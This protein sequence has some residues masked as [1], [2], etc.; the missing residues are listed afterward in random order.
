M[1]KQI[2][3]RWCPVQVAW[4]AILSRPF[5][6]GGFTWTGWDYRGEPTPYRWPDVNSHF[7][8]LDVAGFWKHRAHWYSACWTKPRQSYVLH[9]LPHWNWEADIG[10]VDVWAYSNLEE[11]ELIHP[12]GTSLGR[13]KA[14]QCAH[15]EWQVPY[16]PGNLSVLG[17]MGGQ[18]V[19]KTVVSTTGS[20]SALRIGI[21]DGVG[22]E[23]IVANGQDVGLVFVEVVDDKGA[24]VPSA[25]NMI[26][27]SATSGTLR[28]SEVY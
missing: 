8:I 6:A 12:N 1:W 26:E 5:V 25:S 22:A 28:V 20:P 16:M 9:L 7:G 18:V 15:A 23:G 3:K 4:Q 10:S 13:R 17:Y 2:S 27:V 21:M 11:L 19:K 14:P 24:V